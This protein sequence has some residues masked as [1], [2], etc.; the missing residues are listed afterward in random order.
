MKKTLTIFYTS[1]VHGCF[2]PTDYATGAQIPNSLAGCMAAFRKDGNTLVI[3]GGDTLQ[4]SPFTYWLYHRRQGGECVPARLMNLGGYDFVTLGNHDF[5]YGKAEIERF[6]DELDATC[7]CANVE[8]IRGV[9]KTAV[10]TLGNGLR[11]GLTGVTTAYVTHW[12]KPELMQGIRVTDAFGA[13]WSA[14]G[15][16]R[17]QR[18]DVTVCIYH[19]GFENDVKTGKTMS[20]TGENQGWRICNELGFDILLS[21]HQHMAAEDLCIG[22]TYSCQPPDKARAYIQMSVNCEGGH[23]QATSKLCAPEPKPLE[24]AIELLAPLEN[25][26]SSWLDTPIG[27]LDAEIPAKDPLA[28]ACEGS[29]LANFTNQVQLAFSGADISASGLAGDTAKLSRQVTIREI[30]SVYAFPNTLK[31]VRVRRE[32]LKAALER[33]MEYFSLAADG[34]IISNPDFHKPIV[35]HFNYDSIFGLDVTADL[36]KP[37]GS[38]VC[39]IRYRGEELEESRELLLCLNSYRASGAGGYPAYAAC[40]V[41]REEPTEI[42]ELVMQY[43][44]SHPKITVD[45]RSWLSF[46]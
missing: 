18:V 32:Q 33:S 29:P 15:E 3:D 5:D 36:R 30:V 40:S 26:L 24:A 43:V 28:Q 22:G 4:G 2:S 10:V 27:E 42:A 34:S 17:R 16:L 7:L 44:G 20:Q 41:V 6:L 35:Q 39:S 9:Q 25:E 45:R 21:S 13:A 14:L 38:R 31:T 11:V 19:G 1:D 12:E 23:V 46:K 37:I 8:G